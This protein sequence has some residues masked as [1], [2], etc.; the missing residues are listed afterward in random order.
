MRAHC[1]SG[2]GRP[3]LVEEKYLYRDGN[4]WLGRSPARAQLPV[5]YSRRPPCLPRQRLARRQGHQLR[6]LTIFACGRVRSSSSTPRAR[7]RRSRRPGGARAPRTAMGL[8]QAV[9]VLDPFKAAQVDDSYRSRFNP[10]DALTL[11]TRRPSTRRGGLPMPSSSF[12]R[13]TTRSGTNP[14]GPWS[15]A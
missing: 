2:V 1:H 11:T 3:A 10:L 4:M 5:G 6:S 14:P 9:H 8:G 7:T 12:T 13:A 15:R